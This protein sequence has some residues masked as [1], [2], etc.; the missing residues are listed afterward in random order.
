[1]LGYKP[2]Q[3][4][5]KVVNAAIMDE[6]AAEVLVTLISGM[7]SLLVESKV[8]PD[9]RSARAHLAAMLLSPDT[10]EVG[11]L[12]PDLEAEL[13]KLRASHGKWMV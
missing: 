12:L 5:W 13:A 7:I 3:R 8:C 2:S 6:N 11:A 1:M 4:I 10:G 9:V